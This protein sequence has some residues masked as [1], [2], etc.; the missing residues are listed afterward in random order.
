MEIVKTINVR[1]KES[2]YFLSASRIASLN[3]L[4][5]SRKESLVD[6]NI[7]DKSL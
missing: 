1:H 4:R 3:A 2:T 5:S 7:Q 6:M